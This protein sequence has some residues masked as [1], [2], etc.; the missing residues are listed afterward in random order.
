MSGHSKWHNI[1]VKKMAM[2]AVRGKAFTRHAKLI[3]IAA[4]LHNDGDPSTNSALRVAIDN[5][6]ADSVPNAN[7]ERA[8]KKGLGELKGEQMAEV[9]Y[10]SYAP[11]SVA[12]MIECLTDNRNRTI[13]NV[14]SAIE[15]H[16]GRWAEGGSVGYLFDRKGVVHA[17]KAGL[18]TLPEDLELALIDF[19][20]EDIAASDGSITVTCAMQGWPQIRDVLK[21]NGFEVSKAGL[22]YVAKTHTAITDA[23]TA[24]KLLAFVEAIESDDDVS[25]VHHNAEISDALAAQLG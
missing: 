14:R 17:E 16:G 22:E 1:K 20:A 6:K 4:R 2:D 15:K 18:T 9:L 19:G 10:E 8:I 24:K 13:G 25:E 5:A 23:E 21:S 12:C 3:Q 11:G 7:I